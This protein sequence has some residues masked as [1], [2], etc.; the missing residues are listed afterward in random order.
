MELVL[1]SRI[2]NQIIEPNEIIEKTTGFI[3]GNTQKVSLE[4]LKRDCIIP[5]FSKDNE[6]TISHY[7]FVSEIHKIVKEMFSGFNVLEPDIRVSHNI[8]G[9]IPSAIGKPA[10]ELL[11]HEKTL[12][13]ERCAFLIEIQQQEIVN[14]NPL[15]LSIGGVRAYNQENL[16][17]RKSMEKFKLFIGYNNKVCLNL[18]V[19]TDGFTNEIR[20]SSINDLEENA[21]QLFGSYDRIRHL[22]MMER[23]SKFSLNE[24]EFAHLVGKLRLFQHLNKNDQ[25]DIF[26]FLLNDGQVNT[27]V[28]EYMTCPNFSRD[29]NKEISF[30][31]LYNL[32]T[33]AN[34]SSYID[35]NLERNVSVYEFVNSLGDSVQNNRHNWYLNI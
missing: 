17:S 28:R 3:Q 1:N 33:E 27:V 35:N 26:P 10:K 24:T 6:S 19:S 32:F 12:Y 9:R 13:Y 29:E 30:W 31:K 34:K 5:V 14:G 2:N 16:Y 4:H 22:G 21:V 20:I 7:Q 23:M 11:E 15:T 8:K 18:C 25:K